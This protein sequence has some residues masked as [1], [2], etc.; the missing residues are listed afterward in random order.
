MGVC[1]PFLFQGHHTEGE[2]WRRQLYWPREQ[3]DF[4]SLYEVLIA[5][6]RAALGNFLFS[7]VLILDMLRGG[8]RQPFARERLALRLLPSGL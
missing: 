4:M 5:K 8:G 3:L 2:P 1:W 7:V 6:S